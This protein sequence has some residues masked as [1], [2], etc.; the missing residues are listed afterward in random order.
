MAGAIAVAFATPAV[1][2][3]SASATISDLT[4]AL[5]DLNPLDGIAPTITWSNTSYD[6]NY[7]TSTSASAFGSYGASN[8]YNYAPIGQANSSAASILNAAANASISAS[9]SAGTPSGQYSAS[10]SASATD[11]Y[12]SKGFN[13]AA[14]SG[15]F[16][17]S[18]FSLSANTAVIFQAN[19]STHATASV[20]YDFLSGQ[21][22][23]VSAQAFLNVSGPGASGNGSQSSSDSISSSIQNYYWGNGFPANAQSLASL[24]GSFVN[25]SKGS[26]TGSF[27][28]GVNVSGSTNVVAAAAVAAV[29][30]PESYAMFLAGLGLIGAVAR[31]RQL[32]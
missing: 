7:G 27:Q 1:A 12:S 4:I 23:Y 10:G 16:G 2:A 17:S 30:E 31:R 26:L 3:V 14:Q 24:A 22:E 21:N 5:Y 6:Y 28:L 9:T 20:G 32:R 19:A 8:T 13:A 11:L 25:S 29:P 18:V 15:T